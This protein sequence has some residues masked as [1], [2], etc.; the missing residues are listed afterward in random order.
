MTDLLTTAEVAQRLKLTKSWTAK[1]IRR[2][3]IPSL[4]IGEKTIRVREADLEEWLD[5]KR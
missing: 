4:R 3:E 1:M 2:G 5:S